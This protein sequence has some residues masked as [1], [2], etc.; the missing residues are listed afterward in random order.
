LGVG[1]YSLF[2]NSNSLCC[3]ILLHQEKTKHSD[4]RWMMTEFSSIK[5]INV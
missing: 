3:N 4:E 1:T 2:C 5:N